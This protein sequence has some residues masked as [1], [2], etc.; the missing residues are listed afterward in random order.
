MGTQK[1]LLNEMVL[2]S[3]KTNVKP[4]GEENNHNLKLNNFVINLD[5]RRCDISKKTKKQQKKK[6][7]KN[8]EVGN[9]MTN[10]NNNNFWHN[11][12]QGYKTCIQIE[13]S[14]SQT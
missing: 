8:S 10:N 9:I 5:Q 14:V 7:T 11:K 2:L 12:D 6:S 13:E 4:Y 3:T 1:N